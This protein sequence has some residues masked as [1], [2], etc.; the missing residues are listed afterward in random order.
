MFISITPY[1]KL[2]KLNKQEKQNLIAFNNEQKILNTPFNRKYLYWGETPIVTC[3]NGIQFTYMHKELFYIDNTFFPTKIKLP[4]LNKKTNT[5]DIPILTRNGFCDIQRPQPTQT[6]DVEYL[7]RIYT[8]NINEQNS[9][10]D[11]CLSNHFVSLQNILSAVKER[12]FH[13]NEIAYLNSLQE[14]MMKV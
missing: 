5:I 2:K 4:L 14:D 7:G 9:F 10:D 11:K 3:K 8:I 13:S 6:I 1:L 12:N